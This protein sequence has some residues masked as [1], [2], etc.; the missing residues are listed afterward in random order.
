[1]TYNFK[2]P[3]SLI[4]IDVFVCFYFIHSLC[5]RSGLMIHTLKAALFYRVHLN[6]IFSFYFQIH[7]TFLFV[8]RRNCI[9]FILTSKTPLFV[10]YSRTYRCLSHSFPPTNFSSQTTTIKSPNLVI[11]QQRAASSPLYNAILVA[12]A[13]SNTTVYNCVRESNSTNSL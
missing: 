8:L 10:N 1:M 3:S 12:T 11:R 4:W 7:G 2:L 13:P 5:F 6:Y 9:I